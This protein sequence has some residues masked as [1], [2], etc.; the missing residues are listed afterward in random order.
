MTDLPSGI[1]VSSVGTITVRWRWSESPSK[2][3]RVRSGPGGRYHHTAR[4][5]RDTMM[6][7]PTSTHGHFRRGGFA[8][9]LVDM[10]A[11]SCVAAPRSRFGL[12]SLLLPPRQLLERLA[13][14]GRRLRAD[15]VRLAVLRLGPPVAERRLHVP[16]ALRDDV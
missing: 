12:V 9:W 15:A 8:S 6:A 11:P 7:V 13:Q 4:P 5:T 1:G 16:L 3:G 10:A 14:D 2:V